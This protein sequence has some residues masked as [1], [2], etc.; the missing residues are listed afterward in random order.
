ME[1]RTPDQLELRYNHKTDFNCIM[2]IKLKSQK[3]KLKAR[4]SMPSR[5]IDLGYYFF[6]MTVIGW[7]V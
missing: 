7:I 4:Y 3:G 5:W 2:D 6:G 1:M